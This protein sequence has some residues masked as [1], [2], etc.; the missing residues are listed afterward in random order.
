MIKQLYR[1]YTAYG[2]VIDCD[3]DKERW[4]RQSFLFKSDIDRMLIVAEVCSN[5]IKSTGKC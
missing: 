5:M 2:K 3:I 4:K 1:K